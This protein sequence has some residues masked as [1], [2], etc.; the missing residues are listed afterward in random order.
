MPADERAA[1]LAELFEGLL[2]HRDDA[3]GD[4]LA[5]LVRK[6]FTPPSDEDAGVLGTGHDTTPHSGEPAHKIRK[7]G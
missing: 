1:P 4:G 3:I 2:H 5:T 6:H 7:E